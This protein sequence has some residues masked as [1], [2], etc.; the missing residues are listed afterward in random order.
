MFSELQWLI[1]GNKSEGCPA[2]T[3]PIGLDTK[4]YMVIPICCK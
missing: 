4:L 1:L 2:K 3:V